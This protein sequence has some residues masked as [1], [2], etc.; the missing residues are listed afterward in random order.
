MRGGDKAAGAEL[1]LAVVIYAVCVTLPNVVGAL[2][3]FPGYHQ[4]AQLKTLKQSRRTITLVGPYNRKILYKPASTARVPS[5]RY[6]LR[7]PKSS[8]VSPYTARRNAPMGRLPLSDGPVTLPL[9]WL[10]SIQ[11]GRFGFMPLPRNSTSGAALSTMV[12]GVP[13]ARRTTVERVQ[14]PSAE[15]IQ[16]LRFFNHGKEYALAIVKRWRT[17]N[18]E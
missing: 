12:N 15:P 4:R 18:R 11:T 13:E 1:G 16:S 3:S 8:S 9:Q 14:P 7:P 6:V 5:A 2:K 17:S 10:A